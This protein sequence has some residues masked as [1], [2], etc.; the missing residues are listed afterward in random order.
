[1]LNLDKTVSARYVRFAVKAV[2]HIWS[3]EIQ[4][5]TGSNGDF[6]P[7]K[8]VVLDNGVS[9]VKIYVS[10]NINKDD[11][12]GATLEVTD[13]TGVFNSIKDTQAKIKVRGNSTASGCKKPYNIV[14][15]EKVNP[16][17]I[18]KGK[19]FNLLANLYDKTLMRNKLSY[20]FAISLGLSNTSHS[21]F[22]DVYI[23]DE[24]LGNYLLCEDVGVGKSKVDIDINNN[25]FLLEYEPWQGYSNPFSF[26]TPRFNIVFGL[27]DRDMPTE[28][29]ENFLMK[30]FENAEN[31]L[32]SEDIF[33]IKEYFD[34][35]SFVNFYIANELFKNVDFQTSSTRFY[36]KN[37]KLYA[38]PMWDLDLSSGNANVDYYKHYFIDG[39]SVPGFYCL[40]IYSNA[41]L[42]CDEFHELV[43]SR[44]I[45][46]QDKIINLTTDN[47]LGKNVI[48]LILQRYEKSFIANYEVA[49]WSLTKIHCDYEI[50]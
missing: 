27:N 25:E 41:L 4:I 13:V 14:F 28:E 34:I 24:Y 35:D 23:N 37:N 29:Q 1:T 11:Y 38:G 32:I 19:K 21:E 47:A 18:G 12:V 40:G 5:F 46:I 22:V 15:C 6:V 39:D 31:A 49:G 36:I 48:D 45:E 8:P 50:R 20:D 9:I 16:L 33:K 26:I 30:F 43:K 2:N 7:E 44:Y 3:S 42:E 10:S 17:G